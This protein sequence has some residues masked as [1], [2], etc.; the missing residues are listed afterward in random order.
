MVSYIYNHENMQFTQGERENMQ[1]WSA[2]A[3]ICKEDCRFLQQE[4]WNRSDSFHQAQVIALAGEN[5]N[6]VGTSMSM[7]FCP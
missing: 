5:V 6:E 3:F 2:Y 1:S 7:E 4:W